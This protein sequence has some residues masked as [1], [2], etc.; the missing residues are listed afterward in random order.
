MGHGIQR[1]PGV[2]RQLHECA[3]EGLSLIRIDV[4]NETFVRSLS[5]IRIV[6]VNETFV[7]S[8]ANKFASNMIFVNNS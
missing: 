8:F 6:V 3:G 4:V 5:L 2:Y 1:L 7:R